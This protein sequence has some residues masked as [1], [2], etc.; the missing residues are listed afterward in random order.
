MSRPTNNNS[1]SIDYIDTI[2]K[3]GEPFQSPLL[4]TYSEYLTADDETRT[5]TFLGALNLIGQ[6]GCKFI[7]DKVI[8]YIDD[9]SNVDTCKF[10]ALYSTASVLQVPYKDKAALELLKSVVKCADIIQLLGWVMS[11]NV[12][13]SKY[14]ATR[15]ALSDSDSLSTLTTRAALFDDASPIAIAIK[16]TIKNVITKRHIAPANYAGETN[17]L[18][19]YS[20]N[21]VPILTDII[22]ADQPLYTKFMFA[23]PCVHTIDCGKYNFT[24]H[25]H[26][27]VKL[28]K[29][30][31][32]TVDAITTKMVKRDLPF[33]FNSTLFDP[34]EAAE[35]ILF[36]GGDISVYSVTQQQDINEC[37]TAIN[38]TGQYVLDSYSTE[39]LATLRQLN[40]LNTHTFADE[41][42]LANVISDFKTV[43]NVDI[44]DYI[45]VAGAALSEYD[46]S[47]NWWTNNFSE[48]EANT[49]FKLVT[50]LSTEETDDSIAF[51]DVDSYV[52][53]V[54]LKLLAFAGTVSV[55]REDLK[56]LTLRN[57][58]K[59]TSAI[60]QLATAEYLNEHLSDI[61]DNTIDA[62]IPYEY[63]LSVK[64]DSELQSKLSDIY[65]T[66]LL[67]PSDVAIKE[68]W[69]TTEYFG[70]TKD[71]STD[72]YL[73]DWN[74]SP[75]TVYGSTSTLNSDGLTRDSSDI[76]RFYNNT[77]GIS[78]DLFKTS[79]VE[80]DVDLSTD[81]GMTTAQTRLIAFLNGVYNAGIYN[82]SLPTNI[83]QMFSGNPT[84]AVLRQFYTNYKSYDT[85]TGE[86]RISK[87][88]HPYIWNFTTNES[89]LAA[90][91]N[92][93]ASSNNTAADS[94]GTVTTVQQNTD[95]EL[96]NALIT[97]IPGNILNQ[98]RLNISSYVDDS[99]YWTRYEA[100][101]HTDEEL[102]ICYDGYAYPPFAA[103][104]LAYVTSS[105][106]ILS[107]D[108]AGETLHKKWYKRYGNQ[109]LRTD[110][111]NKENKVL[112]AELQRIKDSVDPTI[113]E[114]IPVDQRR[115]LQNFSVDNYSTSYAAD[116]DNDLTVIYY[117][118]PA[119]PFMRPIRQTV[120]GV[121]LG[122][123][124]IDLSGAVIT[125]FADISFA[126]NAN[127]NHFPN[128]VV[129]ENGNYMMLR[130]S[131]KTLGMFF[132]TTYVN[133]AGYSEKA[134]QLQ[135]VIDTATLLGDKTLEMFSTHI[136]EGGVKT[137]GNN[138]AILLTDV[139]SNSFDE[140]LITLT[141]TS[142]SI[143]KQSID[144]AEATDALNTMTAGLTLG[145]G[146]QT[147][148]MS[149]IISTFGLSND[150]QRYSYINGL[151]T[152]VRTTATLQTPITNAASSDTS[153][154]VSNQFI[155]LMANSNV[156]TTAT[157]ATSTLSTVTSL[158]DAYLHYILPIEPKVN[159]KFKFTTD[160]FDAYVIESSGSSVE[161]Y[162]RTVLPFA[163]RFNINSD[164][165]FNPCYIGDSGKLVLP[166]RISQYQLAKTV[167]VAIELL[168]PK[169]EYDDI[170][171]ETADTYQSEYDVRIH[172]TDFTAVVDVKSDDVYAVTDL[173]SAAEFSLYA[174]AVD[175]YMRKRPRLFTCKLDHF[176]SSTSADT[177]DTSL[178]VTSSGSTFVINDPSNK[179]SAT[180]TTIPTDKVGVAYLMFKTGESQIWLPTA[181]NADTV[182]SDATFNRRVFDIIFNGQIDSVSCNYAIIKTN[183]AIGN[184]YIF[185]TIYFKRTDASTVIVQLSGSIPELLNIE[186]IVVG[187]VAN[188]MTN[189]VATT[190]PTFMLTGSDF[191]ASLLTNTDQN[192]IDFHTRV[193][194]EA[195]AYYGDKYELN[196]NIK[197]PTVYYNKL[198][199]GNTDFTTGTYTIDAPVLSDG[200][201]VMSISEI[202]TV[203]L[204]EIMPDQ[205]ETISSTGKPVLAEVL[206]ELFRIDRLNKYNADTTK[207]I[208]DIYNFTYYQFEY[209]HMVNR[210]DVESN[211]D[212]SMYYVQLASNESDTSEFNYLNQLT[213][214]AW[215][216]SEQSV[217]QVNADTPV[218]VTLPTK[219]KIT[220]ADGTLTPKASRP[221]YMT[222]TTEDTITVANVIP[223]LG[224]RWKHNA[225][226]SIELRFDNSTLADSIFTNA[227][228][229][230][231]YV[232]L[233]NA[234]TSLQIYTSDGPEMFNIVSPIH[235]MAGFTVFTDIPL[236]T[237]VLSNVSDD[238]PKFMLT[239]KSNVQDAVNGDAYALVFDSASTPEIENLN[240]ITTHCYVA[241]VLSLQ[242]T[243]VPQIDTAV[244]L[245]QL[246]F[247]MHISNILS[248]DLEDTDDATDTNA[249]VQINA[250]YGKTATH[251]IENMKQ[252]TAIRSDDNETIQVILKSNIPTDADETTRKEVCFSVADFGIHF[253]DVTEYTLKNALIDA[254]IDDV[255]AM[256]YNNNRLYIA[257][258]FGCDFNKIGI[259][260]V[261][262]TY[263]TDSDDTM[264]MQVIQKHWLIPSTFGT[265]NIP[266]KTYLNN[267]LIYPD[268]SVATPSNVVIGT[269]ADT[270]RRTAI[271]VNQPDDEFNSVITN[272][273]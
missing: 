44:A 46:T 226:E 28:L 215:R 233:A 162:E 24:P 167:G 224:I 136:T 214:T 37:I 74:T 227:N 94:G 225:D 59:G 145:D 43:F 221:V 161:L 245:K 12:R 5:T 210:D 251:I 111:Y 268:T 238:K 247:N 139:T 33:V 153:L 61:V 6:S 56:L 246:A 237:L 88:I 140:Y 173:H 97:D 188:K 123:T 178:D 263:D 100:Y 192:T 21:L 55:I 208:S 199:D 240:S 15:L 239:A 41:R 149:L 76:V 200:S 11:C 99:N 204:G 241:K 17:M 109:L 71:N 91:S 270:S 175:E 119:Y 70:R 8:N 155:H 262:G 235:I 69:D 47:E 26:T 67:D 254:D 166:A 137:I 198:N 170:E 107:T 234:A 256:D 78:S 260:R 232:S 106:D 207:S 10:D 23:S 190:T 203:V 120:G 174:P 264:N 209:L 202:D 90:I 171:D 144:C 18:L 30:K 48:F 205:L 154:D 163:R 83:E 103:D 249:T 27:I 177:F 134:L 122:L 102:L 65:D 168:G 220:Q 86:N 253:H 146:G 64:S 243:V 92:S 124:F 217:D 148:G 141:T 213:Y 89:S 96:L 212:K 266:V 51:F 157:L 68:Y 169:S 228:N 116:V 143:V 22:N 79:S 108:I 75:R 53:D 191:A 13:N 150:V 58:L 242:Q 211:E 195:G 50:A 128:I 216:M 60:I 194:H 118:E 7:Y 38:T 105:S 104:I 172:E 57:A 131:E 151:T 39:S 126:F 19:N 158:T 244:Q 110:V 258:V 201:M 25:E 252:R 87:Q 81:A 222:A 117:K 182:L 257:K 42:L 85:T 255:V 49:Q 66:A 16:A 196:A 82:T 219:V 181:V 20:W 259:K 269:Q 135:Y 152:G 132:V 80:S 138:I 187:V 112:T 115:T 34:I 73:A 165:G 130:L 84:N 164:A 179:F 229:N 1:Q 121:Q 185:D 101:D 3:L 29:A 93:A 176:C 133:A 9:V 54:Y 273:D 72:N 223:K 265:P 14:I 261:L 4:D 127:K 147:V 129:S 35:N 156:T 197:T 36:M 160:G 45:T 40:M 231:S 95:I 32:N 183:G 267:K 125:D 62:V 248:T 113:Y 142:C 186:V 189:S 250:I 236:A 114:E 77:L 272:D 184:P 98:W 31:N 230:L 271:L 193:G 2:A 52:A 63:R 206:N 218:E 180:D 159:R